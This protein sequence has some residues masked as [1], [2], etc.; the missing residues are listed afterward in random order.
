MTFTAKIDKTALKGAPVKLEGN[1]QEVG[2]N[3]PIVKVVT[4]DLQEKPS[5]ARATKRNSSLLY[6]L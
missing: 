6:P 2:N 4:P 1:F 5:V 3:A